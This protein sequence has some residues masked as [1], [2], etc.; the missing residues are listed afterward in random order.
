MPPSPPPFLAALKTATKLFSSLTVSAVCHER[1]TE[2]NKQMKNTVSRIFQSHF[3]HSWSLVRISDS[4]YAFFHLFWRVEGDANFLPDVFCKYLTSQEL[5]EHR[6]HDV[7][8]KKMLPSNLEGLRKRNAPSS[9]CLSSPESKMGSVG[10]SSRS[11]VGAHRKP[12]G[13]RSPSSSRA[14]AGSS[15]CTSS[16]AGVPCRLQAAPPDGWPWRKACDLL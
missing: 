13:L 11:L 6:D 7:E 8:E 3:R 2:D 4:V 14:P 16:Q 10:C 12:G 1:D 15:S 5:R 9:L